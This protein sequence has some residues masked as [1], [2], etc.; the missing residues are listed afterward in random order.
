MMSIGLKGLCEKR[1]A[2]VEHKR[3]REKAFSA[4]GGEWVWIMPN[5]HLPSPLRIGSGEAPA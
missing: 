2:R 1:Q 4:P 3:P 5:L